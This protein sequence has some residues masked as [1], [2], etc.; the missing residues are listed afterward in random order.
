[1]ADI[2]KQCITCMACNEYCPNGANPYD[3]ICT[4]QE[5]K[6][7]RFVSEEIVDVIEDTLAAVPN[8]M[9]EGDPDKPALNLCVMEHAYPRDMTASKMFNGL[10]IVRGADY[11]SRIV[12]LHTGMESKVRAHAQTY[13]DNLKRLNKHQIV[14]V[15]DDCYTMVAKKAPEYGIEVPFEPVHI[16]EYMVGYLNKHMNSIGKLGKRI[17]YQRPCISRYTPEKES[18][19]DEFFDRIGVERVAR[20]YDRQHALCCSF[21]LRETDPERG[22]AIMERNLSDAIEHGADAMVFLCPGCY[23][24]TSDACEKSGLASIFITDLCRMALGEI[25]FSSR[26]WVGE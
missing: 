8:R 19:L 3:L 10:T 16:V 24:L 26:P 12:Y 2:L 17:A 11:F 21:G 20:K 14:F 22:S 5:E 9:I 15:H 18:F 6:G 7:I 25:P 1:Y 4:L 23:W 13:I